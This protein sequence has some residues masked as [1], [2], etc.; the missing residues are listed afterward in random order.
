MIGRGRTLSIGDHNM[1]SMLHS[2]DFDNNPIVPPFFDVEEDFCSCGLFIDDSRAPR[3]GSNG[4][5]VW[6]NSVFRIDFFKRDR[7]RVVELD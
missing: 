3:H 5:D 7:P 4:N 6:A 2:I 1:E